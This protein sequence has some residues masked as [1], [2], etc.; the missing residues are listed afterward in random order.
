MKEDQV[1]NEVIRYLD[2]DCYRYAVLIDG[3]WGCGKTYFVLN[4][5]MN[6]IKDH[7]EKNTNRAVRYISLYGCKSRED[8]EENI[9]WSLL[10]DKFYKIYGKIVNEESFHEK[11]KS[12][13]KRRGETIYAVSQKIMGKAMEKFGIPGKA[14]EYIVDFFEMDKNIFIF[15]DVERCDCP[16]NDVFGYING[17]VEHEGVKVVLVA[18]EK[19]IGTLSR[20]ENKE[21]Q[22]MVS[23]IQ[24]IKVPKEE[25]RYFYRHN[26]TE[27]TEL[28]IEELER[29]RKIIFDGIK[30]DQQYLK[31]R[32]KLVGIT[33]QYEADILSVMHQ[34]I[35]K[36]GINQEL[37]DALNNNVKYFMDLMNQYNYHNLRTFQFFLSKMILLYGE[38]QK[39]NIDERYRT[40][41]LDFITENCFML[42]VE[43]KGNVQAPEER[44][45]KIVFENRRRMQSI[46]DY[47]RYSVFNQVA[48]QSDID[49][50]INT[51]IAGKPDANDPYCLLY[52]EYY[53][54]TQEWVE[55]KMDQILDKLQNHEYGLSIYSKMI[56]MF[57][58]LKNYGF[59]EK[60]LNKAVDLMIKNVIEETEHQNIIENL[61]PS[62]NGKEIEECK[63]IINRINN[64]IRKSEERARQN[65]IK[66]ILERENQWAQELINY[67]EDTS[68]YTPSWALILSVV[69][70]DI[71]V[72]RILSSDSENIN[73]FRICLERIFPSEV[74]KA[75][76]EEDMEA[77][78]QISEKIKEH[79]EKDLIKKKQLE[80]LDELLMQIYRRHEKIE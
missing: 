76:V 4:D 75:D 57:V 12:E 53:L 56:L 47:V 43:F 77:I 40:Q 71:W 41:L 61:V 52:N 51:E 49:M 32:E 37:K 13:I 2:D 11:K 7:E 33:I 68:R 74:T 38:V 48:L 16:I 65:S 66:C 69:P 62:D 19:E 29:R 63:S 36:Y 59:E 8:L 80:L 6:R 64:E 17:L 27:K 24:D 3:E 18:N 5:L 60:Y 1:L 28:N 35:H 26:N 45:Q 72:D 70:N 21:L 78:K 50:Y 46:N 9:C 34:L 67:L 20:V 22:Y 10:D 15:D 25:S 55:Q 54:R 58:R 31:I 23:S 73:N 14:Y 39:F 44:F 30:Y 79:K 42:C